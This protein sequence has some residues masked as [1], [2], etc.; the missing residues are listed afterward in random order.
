VS[1]VWIGKGG[2][3]GWEPWRDG[4]A[5]TASSTERQRWGAARGVIVAGK[6]GTTVWLG[7]R[8][9][10]IGILVRRAVCNPESATVLA[11]SANRMAGQHFG[12]LREF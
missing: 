12:S 10:A 1:S 11:M 8:S 7:G 4:G 2:I 9:P 3:E 5:G 6:P